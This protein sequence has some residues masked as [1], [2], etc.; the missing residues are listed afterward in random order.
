LSSA[1]ASAIA[2]L[3]RALEVDPKNDEAKRLQAEF[4][5]SG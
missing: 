4:K 5:K 1:S 3:A 2:E